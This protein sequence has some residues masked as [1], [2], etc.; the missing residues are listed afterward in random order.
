MQM[1]SLILGMGSVL[2][3]V[4]MSSVLLVYMEFEDSLKW[5]V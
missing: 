3:Q 5:M 2:K 1:L 4:Q